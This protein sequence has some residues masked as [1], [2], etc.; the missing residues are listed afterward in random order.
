MNPTDQS[1]H[2]GV[3]ILTGD[4]KKAIIALSIPVIIAMLLQSIYNLVD[5]IWVAGL[6]EDALAAVGF[7]TPLFLIL[8]GLGN[9]LGAGVSSAIARRIGAGDRRGADRAAMQGIGLILIISALITPF[10]VF[11]AEPIAALLGAGD[12]TALTAEYARIVFAGTPFLLFAS[13]S[14]AIF[15]AEGSTKK[16][17][18]AMGASAVINCILDPILIYP[19]GLGVAGAAWA[20]LIS[21][22]MVSA[23]IFYWLFIERSTYV[24]LR[25]SEIRPEREIAMD[26]IKVGIPGSLQFVMMSAVAILINALLVTTSGTDAVA[27]Y[28]AGWRVV[29]FSIIPLIGISIATVSIAGASYGARNFE[30]VHSVHTIALGYGVLISLILTAATWLLAPYLAIIFTYSPESAHLAPGITAFLRTICWF[31]PFVPA[32]M[33][34]SAIF[35]GTGRGVSALILEFFRNIV[36]IAVF[37][38]ILGISLSYG[39]VG[40]WWGVVAGNTC[41]GFF[42]LFWVRWYIKRLMRYQ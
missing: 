18:Y 14:Y 23:L 42:S 9:G 19:M 4:P 8:I 30:R 25:R 37:I 33:F 32:G 11:W 24:T 22:L 2:K 13:I 5:A 36:F 12:A 6:G 15:N 7:V 27:V 1:I 10:L 17:M 41:G 28:T 39:E 35:Q 21:I 16:T 29:L 31:F 34:S 20:T 3:S 26:I 40:I 38:W